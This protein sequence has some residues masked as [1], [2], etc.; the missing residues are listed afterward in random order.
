MVETEY[1]LK[2]SEKIAQLYPILLSK[3]GKIIDGFHRLEADPNW[4]T[5]T[6]EEIDTEEKLLV[7]R[8]VSNW[9][10]RQVS[11]EEKTEW[12]NDLAEIYQKQGYKLVGKRAVIS[13]ITTRNEIVAKIHEMTGLAYTTIM[14]FID[15]KY[16]SKHYEKS[17]NIEPR[18][19]ASQVIVKR[20]G[21]DYGSQVVERHREEVEQ[22][23]RPKIEMEIRERVEEEITP[24]IK[25]ELSQ[26]TEFIIETI[27]KAPDVL[28]KISERKIKDAKKIVHSLTKEMGVKEGTIYTVGE[29]ECPHCKKHYLIKCN[30]KKDWI[31]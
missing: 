17:R 2:K 8:A 19:P 18:V 6:I 20:L 21:E 7:A 3:D 11:K 26:D 27:K 31:E 4:K 25:E 28:P 30:G 23:L 16:K 1:D 22:E 5:Q 10:R 14:G 15:S 29:Y 12:I 24:K 13:N 9:N